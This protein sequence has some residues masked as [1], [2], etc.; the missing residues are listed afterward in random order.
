VPG[1]SANGGLLLADLGSVARALIEPDTP[2]SRST[3]RAR[4]VAL[5]RYIRIAG[6]WFGRDPTA[7]LAS[8]DA[9]L[10]ARSDGAWYAAG[11]V[12]A[13]SPGRRRRRGPTLDAEDLHR[14]VDATPDAESL[15]SMRDRAVVAILCFSGL[16]PEEVL[17]LR[18]EDIESLRE[19]GA[20]RG[21]SAHVRRGDRSLSLPLAGRASAELVRFAAAVGAGA[22]P[23]SGHVFRATSKTERP[24]G[25]RAAR[26]LVVAA[27]RR[28]GLPAVE[29]SELR[30]ACAQWMRTIGLS[31]HEVAAAFGLARVRSVDRLLARHAALDAQR[32]VREQ[33]SP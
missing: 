6:P 13:G 33:L 9:S 5:Q 23:L 8:L 25:Y 32:R 3:V 20:Y 31:Q 1:E 29:A 11:T 12:V 17:A 14:I 30:A 2:V 10:P 16:R 24:L 15:R 19:Q 7:D 21:L 28:A 18:W 4:F 27:C 26:Y 22:Q